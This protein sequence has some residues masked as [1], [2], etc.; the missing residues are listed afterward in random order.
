[1]PKPALPSPRETADFVHFVADMS[2]ELAGQAESHGLRTLA[3][4][5]R[6]ARLEAETVAAEA[7]APESH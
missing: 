6:M 3:H 4:L 1:M 5:F 2:R 7:P